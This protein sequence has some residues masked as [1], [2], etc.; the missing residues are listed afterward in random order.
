MFDFDLTY[1]LVKIKFY[2]EYNCKHTLQSILFPHDKDYRM[3]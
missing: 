1:I 2:K 3:Y